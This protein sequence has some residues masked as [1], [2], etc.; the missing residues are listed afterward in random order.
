LFSRTISETGLPLSLC[1]FLSLV[2]EC[3][4]SR[5]VCERAEPAS[6]TRIS[7][8]L[9]QLAKG[10]PSICQ[11]VRACIPVHRLRACRAPA[12]AVMTVCVS[13]SGSIPETVN[14][15]RS[16]LLQSA[17]AHSSRLEYVRAT[18]NIHPSHYGMA[19]AACC[20]RSP[21]LRVVQATQQAVTERGYWAAAA[22]LVPSP[23]LSLSAIPPFLPLPPFS[24]ILPLWRRRP[25]HRSLARARATP[26]ARASVQLRLSAARLCVCALSLCDIGLT[27]T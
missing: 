24:S 23:P 2:R 15:A 10:I 14:C 8:K 12:A 18:P 6:P 21:S 1:L 5:S 13:A 19:A 27:R 17:F 16:I 20:G 26:R 22:A 7:G 11:R 9:H 3:G 4:R 25:R